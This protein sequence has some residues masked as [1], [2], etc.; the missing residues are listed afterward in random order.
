M[1][2]DPRVQALLVKP[3]YQGRNIGFDFPVGWI[4]IIEQMVVDLEA[5]PNGNHLRC[6]QQKEKFGSLRCYITLEPGL[7]EDDA[8]ELLGLAGNIISIASDETDKICIDCGKPGEERNTSWI[9]VMCNE[10][11]EIYKQKQIKQ[12]EDAERFVR[13]RYGNNDL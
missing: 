2:D 12:H 10:H 7:S 1:Y 5:L 13:E 4:S 11:F 8:N 6:T 3:F 9:R